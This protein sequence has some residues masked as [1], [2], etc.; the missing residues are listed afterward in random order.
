MSSLAPDPTNTSPILVTV[1]FSETVVGFLATDIVPG[2][3]TVDNFVDVGSGLY[4]F[5]LTP[6]GE[7]PVTADIAADIA[8][9]A[10]GNGNLVATQFSRMLVPPTITQQPVSQTVS[11]GQPA[12][13]T[14]GVSGGIGPISYQW[15]RDS[16]DLSG[17][18]QSAYSIASAQMGDQGSYT[19]LVTDETSAMFVESD[20]AI[21]NVIPG[22]PI[23]GGLVLSAAVLAAGLAG[24]LRL[25]RRKKE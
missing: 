21:L 10:A 17:A 13:F 6:T 4:T 14:V 19:C 8:A 18:D 5:D 3:G 7:S 22:L 24:I 23:A 11:Q 2:N 15:R 25:R 9:D 20:A 1:T 12:T 16:M